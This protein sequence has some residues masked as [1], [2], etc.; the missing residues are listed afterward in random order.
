MLID[1]SLAIGE[2]ERNDELRCAVLFAHG[3]HFTA[4]LD[5]MELT[6]KLASGAFKY[7]A[8]GIDPWGVSKPRRRK[9]V[10]VAI[11]GT[12]W[13]AGIELMLNADIAIAASNARF[14]HLEVL[15][16]FSGG[17]LDNAVHSGCGLGSGHAL[18]AYR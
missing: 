11:E 6:P 14:A 15:R 4:G 7:P 3:E 13:T 8:E 2:Y 17:R 10:V 18:H 16:G 5:L 9:P 12:C 1:L